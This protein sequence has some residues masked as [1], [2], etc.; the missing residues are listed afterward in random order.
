MGQSPSSFHSEFCSER[1]Q[2]WDE[3]AMA[4][5]FQEEYRT[6]LKSCAL[7]PNA[8]KHR[9]WG[10]LAPLLPLPVSSYPASISPA[11]GPAAHFLCSQPR[12]D[13]EQLGLDPPENNFSEI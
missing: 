5:C 11:A 4:F 1:A 6:T 13:G 9:H 7:H 12:G 3:E 2:C 8:G 10:F